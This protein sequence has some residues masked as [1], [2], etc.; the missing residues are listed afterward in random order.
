MHRVAEAAYR[1]AGSGAGPQ[2]AG[3]PRGARR[4]DDVIDAD[5]SEA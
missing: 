5:Y 1:G 4:N 3:E 2:P